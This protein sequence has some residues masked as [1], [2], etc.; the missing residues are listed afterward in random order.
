MHAK[1][2]L[3]NFTA[4]TI[5]T[6]LFINLTGVRFLRASTRVVIA[7]W[8]SRAILTTLYVTTSALTIVAYFTFSCT[9]TA[10]HRAFAYPIFS[11][12]KRRSG[13]PTTTLRDATHALTSRACFTGVK[14]SGYVFGTFTYTCLVITYRS[15]RY[16]Y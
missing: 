13:V 16:I 6:N 8:G 12:T 14:A 1:V 10:I 11:V 7:I 5:E 3:T 2:E 9:C 15:G 4:V